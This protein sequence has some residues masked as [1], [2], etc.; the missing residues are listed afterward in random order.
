M[1]RAHRARHRPRYLVEIFAKIYTLGAKNFFREGWNVFDFFVI[2]AAL[3]V[4]MAH[5]ISPEGFDEVA[6][7]LR[8]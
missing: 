1:P 7:Q 2:A 4:V 5:A 3:G 8:V 6:T